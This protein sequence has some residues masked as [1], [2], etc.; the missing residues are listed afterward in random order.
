MNSQIFETA[1]N[2]KIEQAHTFCL[3]PHKS[4]AVFWLS[5][6]IFSAAVILFPERPAWGSDADI[7]VGPDG[8]KGYAHEMVLEDVLEILADEAGVAIYLDEALI[9]ARVSFNIPHAVSADRAIQIIVQP[10]S[11]AVVYAPSS[12]RHRLRI[13]QIQVYYGHPAMPVSDHE[14]DP[15]ITAASDVDDDAEDQVLAL[16]IEYDDGSTSER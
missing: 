3:S 4:T 16:P 2:L 9:E 6:M 1:K 12:D 14:S 10:Y 5:I 8:I 13:D 11:H 15:I 7:Q